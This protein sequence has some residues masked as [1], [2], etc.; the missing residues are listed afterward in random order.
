MLN[1]SL[2]FPKYSA[3]RFRIFLSR[4]IQLSTCQSNVHVTTSADMQA[5]TFF[6]EYLDLW[7]TQPEIRLIGLIATIL[8]IV[9]MIVRSEVS[10]KRGLGLAN[11]FAAAHLFGI[12]ANVAACISIIA[13]VRLFLGASTRLGKSKRR[14]AVLLF[15][16]LYLIIFFLTY[17][18]HADYLAL[19]GTLINTAASL[20]LTG[21]RFRTAL[22]MGST[23]W[24]GYD[25]LV[26]A[27]EIAIATFL[28][29]I[30]GIYSLQRELKTTK[31]DNKRKQYEAAST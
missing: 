25:V 27:Y 21:I 22:V 28:G 24:L 13:F 14:Q 5:P 9:S 16:T 19:S 10:V 23:F 7:S 15:S 18:Q 4:Q 30:A 29:L 17:K 2:T 20:L 3:N 8:F 6:Q 12:G 11:L 1:I 26:G 31:N